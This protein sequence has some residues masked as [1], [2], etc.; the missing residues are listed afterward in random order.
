MSKIRADLIT[1]VYV[2]ENRISNHISVIRDELE[3]QI[4]D[5]CTGQTVL[6]E[7]LDKQQK[8]VISIVEQQTWNLW[9]DIEGTW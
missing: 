8:N 2:M 1:Q 5:V 7:R 4:G 6:E 3:T 9:E